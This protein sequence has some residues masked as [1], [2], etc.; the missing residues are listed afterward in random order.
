[1]K[2]KESWKEVGEK[3]DVVGETWGNGQ[4]WETKEP[5]WEDKARNIVTIIGNKEP[6]IRKMGLSSMFLEAIERSITKLARG[7]FEEGKRWHK[8]YQE[9]RS[10]GFEEGIKTGR[11]Q[12]KEQNWREGV[13]KDGLTQGRK[14]ALTSLLAQIEKLK[15]VGSSKEKDWDI[16]EAVGHDKA[17]AT[18]RELIN[19]AIEK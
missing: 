13:Y 4:N 7:A 5:S 3:M 8:T 14:D 18:I 12:A 11:F 9:G 10:D 1:M 2:D 16:E 6:E 17:I 19:N 15:I